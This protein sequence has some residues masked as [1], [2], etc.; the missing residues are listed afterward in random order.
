MGDAQ[1]S[2]EQ[3]GV[4]AAEV[5]RVPGVAVLEVGEVGIGPDQSG[6]H[7]PTEEELVRFLTEVRD[8][9]RKDRRSRK[10]R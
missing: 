1:P 5:D 3:S 2:V 9:A 10:S 8:K 4:D 6:F 7:G